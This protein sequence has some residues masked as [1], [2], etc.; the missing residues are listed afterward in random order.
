MQTVEGNAAG[1]NELDGYTVAGLSLRLPV[2]S[3]PTNTELNGQRSPTLQPAHLTKCVSF[4]CIERMAFT[5]LNIKQPA[6]QQKSN[7]IAHTCD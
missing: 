4:I 6:S 1:F 2:G 3:A 5:L 7:P